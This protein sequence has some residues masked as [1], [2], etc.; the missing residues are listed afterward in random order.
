M[1]EDELIGKVPTT[2]LVHV[3]SRKDT[4]LAFITPPY[5][6][7]FDLWYEPTKMREAMMA[8]CPSAEDAIW[9]RLGR[10]GNIAIEPTVGGKSADDLRA[11]CPRDGHVAGR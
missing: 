5:Q 11:L 9:Q 4:L 6:Q 2:W 10:D 7:A 3:S 1:L 8:L